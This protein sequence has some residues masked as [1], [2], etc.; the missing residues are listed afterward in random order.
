MFHSQHPSGGSRSS[1]TQVP[2]YLL[3]SEGTR[4]TSDV[5]RYMQIKTPVHVKKK[6]LK[7]LKWLYSENS[8][9]LFGCVN[10]F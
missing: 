1:V 3:A 9:G 5:H 7:H 8:L 4:H 10:M 6:V 2:V